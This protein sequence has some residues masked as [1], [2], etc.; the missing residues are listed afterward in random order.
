MV[1]TYQGNLEAFDKN[2]N[3]LRAGAVLRLPDAAALGAVSTSEA[4]AEVRRQY[5]AWHASAPAAPAAAGP[6]ATP[7]P[8]A[9]AADSGRLRLVPPGTAA[10][11]GAAAAAS[12]AEA[13]ALEGKIQQLQSQLDESQRLLA[14]RNADLA[15]LQAQLAAPQ[16]AAK[17]CNAGRRHPRASAAP[18]ARSCR[19][20]TAPPV[21][22]S[23]A[24]PSRTRLGRRRSRAL[25]MSLARAA[26][27]S[28]ARSSTRC[29]STGGRWRRWCWP[30]SPSS[31]FAAGASGGSR[32]LMTPSSRLNSRA[33]TSSAQ[34][35]AAFDTAAADAAAR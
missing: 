8:A 25:R 17:P 23:A 14:V 29:C 12:A 11:S 22:S 19:R 5:A 32:A 4:L 18:E 31:G 3:V 6:T 24:R 30:L 16:G 15:K 34:H 7:A 13:R 21:E 10:G 9:A 1:A 2:M 20:P 35:D 33:D 28:P 26:E 27:Q